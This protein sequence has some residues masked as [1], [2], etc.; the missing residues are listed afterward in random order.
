MLI[1]V[2]IFSD[3]NFDIVLT[4][5]STVCN[6]LAN[7]LFL[8][9]FTWVQFFSANVRKL[10]YLSHS[11][12]SLQMFTA[13]STNRRQS[14]LN[15]YP[16]ILFIYFCVKTWRMHRIWFWR[17]GECM[18]TVRFALDSTNKCDNMLAF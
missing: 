18:I 11:Y 7:F 2:Y 8:I 15:S 10:N 13:R 4:I 17:K 16:L 6:M 9:L 1:F 5:T 3:T 12:H 14:L